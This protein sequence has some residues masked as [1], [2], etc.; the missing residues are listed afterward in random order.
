MLVVTR[1]V[2]FSVHTGQVTT[3]VLKVCEFAS[4]AVDEEID[5]NAA[6]KMAFTIMDF[7]GIASSFPHFG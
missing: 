6:K 4:G 3:S 7:A 1:I 2:T 5:N